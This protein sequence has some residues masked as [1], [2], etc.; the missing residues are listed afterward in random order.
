MTIMTRSA[1]SRERAARRCAYSRPASTS[2]MEHGPTI[3]SRRRS[4][5][6]ISLWIS[7]RER[8]TNSA[9]T[10]F[11]GVSASSAEGEGNGRVSTTLMSD[12][13]CIGGL[14]RKRASVPVARD[15][16]A[17]TQED[18]QI[19]AKKVAGRLPLDGP[20]LLSYFPQNTRYAG[21][22]KKI[23]PPQ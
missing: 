11:F 14:V 15:F 18:L 4:S 22:L 17:D 16:G 13:L 9:W 1:T 20:P 10:S 21:G 19:W 6:K 7:W 8:V 3:M 5:V 2:W 12:V 23:L